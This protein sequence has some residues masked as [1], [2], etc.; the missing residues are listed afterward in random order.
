MSAA[1]WTLGRDG[2]CQLAHRIF[3]NAI[4]LPAAPA[5]GLSTCRYRDTPP[6]LPCAGFYHRILVNLGTDGTR[7]LR[8][9]P[10]FPAFSASFLVPEPSPCGIYSSSQFARERTVFMS[11]SEIANQIRD[12]VAAVVKQP[13]FVRWLKAEKIGE[14]L[15]LLNNSFI[16][17]QKLKTTKSDLYLGIPA[18]TAS[19]LG[20]SNVVAIRGIAFNTDF[21]F[22]ELRG[23]KK[24]Q[25]EEIQAAI[26][27]E[28]GRLG[29]IVM[30]LIGEVLDNVITKAPIGH[31][32]FSELELNP[33]SAAALTVNG[34]TVHVNSISNEEAVWAELERAHGADLP[35]DL[36]EPLAA[37]LDY[38]RKHHYAILSLPGEL[39]QSHPLLDSFVEA[40]RQNATR[41]KKA[42]SK[43][44]RQMDM[45]PGE[46][47]DV[48]RIAYNFATDAVLVIRL[49]VSICDLKPIVRW[50]T[51]D[52][53][54]RL[55]EIFRNL[56]WAKTKDKPSLDA[57]QQTVNNARN[58]AFHRL[59]PVDNTLRV[60]LEGTKLGRITLRLFPEYADRNMEETMDYED[61][62]L[63]EL[64]TDFT[65]V[66]E[67]SVSPQ[68]WQ[69]NIAVMEGTIELLSR[70]SSALKLLSTAGAEPI[71]RH[72]G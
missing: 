59:L 64:L 48:L 61:R 68:F 66:S 17:R 15:I 21:K 4:S 9:L 10:S 22:V 12:A 56:P 13:E 52:E 33:T 38:V 55:A 39:N 47:N 24:L 11:R 36:A 37:A 32:L 3:R 23:I 51:V 42:W 54:L 63:V 53:W 28:L 67:K 16:F 70:T 71:V 30:V 20:I 31:S 26:D 2:L 14:G 72:V 49:L 43:C 41:Y 58:K 44:K 40:L 19:H 46:L 8:S 50:C 7:S 5:F 60:E 35:E 25:T 27:K 6:H 69:R 18:R 1:L 34:K 45:D 57:Y 29:S 62:A 65:R